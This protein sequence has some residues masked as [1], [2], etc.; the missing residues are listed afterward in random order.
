MEGERKPRNSERRT[1]PGT[2]SPNS[3]TGAF[4]LLAMS[5]LSMEQMFVLVYNELHQLAARNLRGERDSHT[6]STTA[7]VHEAWLELNKLNRIQWQNRGHFLAIAAQA[8][9]RILIDY[10]VARRRDKR[11]GGQTSS[12]STTVMRSRSHT[13][14]QTNCLARRGARPAPGHR[15]AAG[16][17]RRVPLLRRDECRRDRRRAEC[18]PRDRQARLGDRARLVESRAPV[19]TEP[20]V[21]RDHPTA[22]R[23]QRVQAV[24][25]AAVECDGADR[26]RLLD[27]RAAKI[28]N[29]G[30]KW[31]RCSRHTTARGRSTASRR[32]SRRRRHGRERSLPA[33]RGAG[34]DSMPFWNCVEAGGMGVVYKAHDPRL[35]RHVALKFLQPHLDS[36]S[37][38]KQRF[39]IEAR[40]AAALD[41]PNI[42]TILEI[43]ET[44]SGQLF[45]AMPLYDGETVAARLKRG[46]LP[47]DEAL[48]IAVQVARGI[49]AAHAHGVVHRDIKPSNV[50]LL[51]DGT[52]K[53]LDFGIATIEDLA[54]VGDATIISGRSR[55]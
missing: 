32:R 2:W 37:A 10:A 22:E 50:M 26:A 13:S 53:V 38:P 6:L 51:R 19:M 35:G 29:C 3:A 28:T 49:G 9:R 33:G 27:E 4:A 40:A 24:F 52:V 54:P 43:G 21:R 16:A 55:T 42:C 41:H 34:S 47:F 12:R 25:A 39:L 46:R 8:M 17:C 14:G 18:L 45:L 5:T 36:Q 7:L 11:G 30:A 1:K 44:D 20:G 15:R 23:W 48:P 31:S